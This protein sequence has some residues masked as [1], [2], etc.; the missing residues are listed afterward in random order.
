MELANMNF[1]D[2]KSWVCYVSKVAKIDQIIKPL[3][4]QFKEINISKGEVEGL[5]FYG[6]PVG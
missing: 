2:L 4:F 3:Y 6:E 5:T 1:D